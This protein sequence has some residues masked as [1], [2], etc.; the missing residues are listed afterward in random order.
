VLSKGPRLP[1]DLPPARLACFGCCSA[2]AL[3]NRSLHLIEIEVAGRDRRQRIDL[4][5]RDLP[6]I[7]PGWD[8]AAAGAQTAASSALPRLHL[9]PFAE[10]VVEVAVLVENHGG[11]C[12][13]RG[14]GCPMQ[15]EQPAVHAGAAGLEDH[16]RC[17]LRP[18]HLVVHAGGRPDPEPGLLLPAPLS[19]VGRR[20][21]VGRLLVIQGPMNTSSIAAPATSESSL[22]FVGSLGQASTGSV[23]S[24]EVDLDHFGVL[25]S[26]SAPSAGDR[27]DPPQAPSPAA[28]APSV[29]ASSV[30]AGD[31]FLSR[32]TLLAENTRHVALGELDRHPAQEAA[33][34]GVREL[35]R[36]L[37]LEIGSPPISMIRGEDVNLA[38]FGHVSKAPSGSPT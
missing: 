31:Q 5:G 38:G 6:S 3:V 10:A 21:V 22:T 33:R 34:G 12:R 1:S 36:L 2:P 28:A 16:P 19:T 11:V 15:S 26:A 29:R 27:P 24:I 20:P 17:T 25:A 32:A 35:K 4:G 8:V 30:N 18:Q 13:R 14:P 37:Q 7:R 23:R 9:A